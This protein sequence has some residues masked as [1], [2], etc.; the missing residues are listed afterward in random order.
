M[1]T[2]G[3]C[4]S[5][6]A[7]TAFTL[8]VPAWPL[9][10]TAAPHQHVQHS[11]YTYQHGHWGAL[12][13]PISTRSIHTACTQ[14][15]HWG[16]LHPTLAVAVW[17]AVLHN[18]QM[19]QLFFMSWGRQGL[20]CLCQD[21]SPAAPGSGVWRVCAMAPPGMQ[22]RGEQ[23]R[24]G[25]IEQHGHPALNLAGC[26]QLGLV[27]YGR[28]LGLGAG[29]G[30]PAVPGGA[31][32]VTPGSETGGPAGPWGVREGTPVRGVRE[33]PNPSPLEHAAPQPHMAL[34]RTNPAPVSWAGSPRT[35]PEP[36][37][38]YHTSPEP[39]LPRRLDPPAHI[40]QSAAHTHTNTPCTH[41]LQHPLRTYMH[42]L[43]TPC[44][45]THTHKPLHKPQCPLA[46][47]HTNTPCTHIY[48]A[49]PSTHTHTLHTHPATP[50]THIHTHTLNS[51]HTD[52]LTNPLH[53][54]QHP[55]TQTH[56]HPY[57]HAHKP[58][59]SLHAHTQ[60]PPRNT[61]CSRTA[62]HSIHTPIPSLPTMQRLSH[63]S[64]AS[65][66]LGSVA[67]RALC[68]QGRGGG[69]GGL[70]TMEGEGASGGQVPRDPLGLPPSRIVLESPGIKD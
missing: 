24:G 48:P 35:H 42:T 36:S 50:S 68:F 40:R 2:G 55:L 45:Q 56:Q 32:E 20:S 31:G 10:G 61:P 14:H 29:C 49:T 28:G 34:S 17:M 53:T 3:H 22:G 41:T 65:L 62:Q 58:L 37:G 21:R 47:T 66:L 13:L 7:H 59:H 69:A 46:H 5:P 44:T 27:G 43:E 19:T 30:H 63:F 33:P 11:H 12:Q 64:P 70:C 4:S 15:G 57:T 54:P 8:H 67:C 9:G 60:P 6:S 18:S 26:A 1:A 16:A 38:P 25:G 23:G 39:G 51:L 52:T